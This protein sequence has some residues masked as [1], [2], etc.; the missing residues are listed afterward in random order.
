MFKK[1]LFLVIA[2][3]VLIITYNLLGQIFTTLKA[4]ERLKTATDELSSLA[5]KNNELKKQLTQVQTP[6]FIE[7]QARD[8]LGLGK[9]NETIVVIPDDKLKSVLGATEEQKQDIKLPNWQGWLR[10]FWN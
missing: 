4:G 6:D 2:I 7:Q 10:L 8:K 5:Q 3:V 1:P 9:G